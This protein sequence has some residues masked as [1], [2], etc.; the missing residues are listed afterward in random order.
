MDSSDFTGKSTEK[1]NIKSCH[2]ITTKACQNALKIHKQ[3]H[4]RQLPDALIPVDA[5]LNYFDWLIT[6]NKT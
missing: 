3:D 6:I 1:K 4:L 2:L 5:E